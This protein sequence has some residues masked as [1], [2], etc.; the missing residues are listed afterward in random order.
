MKKLLFLALFACH[1]A[2]AEETMILTTEDAPPTNM[3]AAEALVQ[4][5]GKRVRQSLES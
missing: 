2:W 1:C 3:L 4:L 5:D